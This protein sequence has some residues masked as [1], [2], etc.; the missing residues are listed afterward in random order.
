[1]ALVKSCDRVL[2]KSR[3]P[4]WPKSSIRM[5]DSTMKDQIFCDIAAAMRRA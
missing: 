1:M 3:G 2:G 4:I 5:E